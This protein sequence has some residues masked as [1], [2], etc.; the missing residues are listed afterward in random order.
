MGVK[1]V[2]DLTVKE[3]RVKTIILNLSDGK[4]TFLT[5]TNICAM[6]ES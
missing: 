4:S 1:F 5:I 6:I 2:Q 3:C